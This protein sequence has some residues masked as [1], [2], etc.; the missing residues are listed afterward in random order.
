MRYALIGWGCAIC[1]YRV[2]VSLCQNPDTKCSLSGSFVS[3]WGPADSHWQVYYYHTMFGMG[4]QS[5]W[6]HDRA[7]LISN[8]MFMLILHGT[9]QV[10]YRGCVWITFHE[11]ERTFSLRCFI[12]VTFHATRYTLHGV[13]WLSHSNGPVQ[14]ILSLFGTVSG[15][16]DSANYTITVWCSV[17]IMWQCKL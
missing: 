8:V 11:A 3:A 15:S 12:R 4:C 2:R 16:W 10:F 5:H 13:V 17:W 6:S 9:E 14:T 7:C 1:P